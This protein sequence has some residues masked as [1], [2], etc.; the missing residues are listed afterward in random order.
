MSRCISWGAWQVRKLQ[1]KGKMA[2]ILIT[3]VIKKIG[4][5]MKRMPDHGNDA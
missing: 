1:R 5:R 4:R 2:Q 3:G